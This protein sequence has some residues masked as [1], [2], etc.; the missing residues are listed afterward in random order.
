MIRRFSQIHKIDYNETFAFIVRINILRAILILIVIKNLE[1]DQI[2][3]NNAFTK[4]T[5]KYFIYINT[6][7]L[8][9][10]KQRKYLRLL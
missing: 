10:V 6:F 5:L 3:V 2:N 1:I 9:D 4:S 8:I 7:S